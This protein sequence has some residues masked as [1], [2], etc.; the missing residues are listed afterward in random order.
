VEAAEDLGDLV[1]AAPVAA[2]RAEAGRQMRGA[3]WVRK[4]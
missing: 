4:K 2:E 3:R 1:A